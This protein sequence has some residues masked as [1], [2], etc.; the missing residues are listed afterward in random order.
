SAHPIEACFVAL[1]I[2]KSVVNAMSREASR[3]NLGCG[4]SAPAG[5]LNVDGSWNAWLSN[6]PQ[7]RKALQTVGVIHPNQGSEWK[8]RPL[9]HDLT[10]RLPFP[11]NTFSAVYA[12]HVL[13]HL[14]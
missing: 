4:P 5:W 2:M 1:L 11:E 6:H 3:L 9:V 12:S 13:E 10:K 8:V 14:Y 7:L